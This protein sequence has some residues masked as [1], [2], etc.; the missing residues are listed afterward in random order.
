MKEEMRNKENQLERFEAHLMI[1]EYVN[2]GVSRKHRIKQGNYRLLNKIS[3][4]TIV[5]I[6]LATTLLGSFSVAQQAYSASDTLKLGSILFNNQKAKV[7]FTNMLAFQAENKQIVS[8]NAEI[9]NFSNQEINFIDYWVK[10]KSMDGVN[11]PVSLIESDKNK[12]VINP[13]S[14]QVFT[15][16]AYTDSSVNIKN[17]KVQFIKWDFSMANYERVLGSVA[18]PNKY[19][20]VMPLK[21]AVTIVNQ[22]RKFDVKVTSSE[23]ISLESKNAVQ[24]KLSAKNNGKSSVVLPEMKFYIQTTAGLLYDLTPDREMNMSLQ[25]MMTEN[26]ILT[27]STPPNIHHAQSRLVITRKDGEVELPLTTMQ[28]ELKKEIQDPISDKKVISMDNGKMEAWV[29]GVTRRIMTDKLDQVEVGLDVKNIG[30]QNLKFPQYK[31]ILK[32]DTGLMYVLEAEADITSV[33]PLVTQRLILKTELPNEVKT[34]NVQILI[35]TVNENQSENYTVAKFKTMVSN[36][37][38]TESIAAGIEYEYTNQNGVYGVTLA[39]V[40][41]LPLADE[42]I[43]HASFTIENKDVQ[44]LPIPQLTGSFKL[45]QVSVNHDQTVLVQHDSIVG[46]EPGQNVKVSLYTKIPYTY[47]ANEIMVT[48]NEKLEETEA[49]I[50]N[51]KSST[52]VTQF[53]SIEF[54]DTL[55]IDNIGSRANVTVKT[56]NTLTKG[57]SKLIYALV[58]V[59]NLER[60]QSNIPTLAAQLM[61]NDELY[62]PM[63]VSKVEEKVNPLSKVLLGMWTVVPDG[64][65]TSNTAI[66]IGEKLDDKGTYLNASAMLIPISG[67]VASNIMVNMDV[68]PNTLSVYNI[69]GDLPGKTISFNMEWKSFEYYQVLPEESKIT[70]EFKQ[71]AAEYSKSYNIH[72]DMEFGLM[73]ETLVL[74]VADLYSKMD[75]SSQFKFRVHIELNGYKRLIGERTVDWL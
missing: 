23:I 57:N 72:E 17:L 53:D 33:S 66:I 29:S 69:K 43:V 71:G 63:Q 54:G 1:R 68:F 18:I 67:K 34:E 19:A 10:L 75:S 24:I 41:R 28:I 40:E 42:D 65:T 58:E 13:K 64:L 55:K 74:D 59:E 16:Y 7:I 60:R 6:L 62:F 48:L 2:T 22:S 35:Q 27:G 50:Q 15:F 46:I 49:L 52:V 8:F 14:S 30:Q 31:Y 26:F 11:Y 38:T 21:Q 44:Y 9:Q 47:N 32:S 70:V 37:V 73:K 12:N 51:F 25:P 39:E 61:T 4:I 5:L 45:N 3:S 36:R 20:T 56:V